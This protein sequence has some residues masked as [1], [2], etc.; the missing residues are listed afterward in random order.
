MLNESAA[1]QYVSRWDLQTS[2]G[3]LARRNRGILFQHR[4]HHDLISERRHWLTIE[5]HKNATL[6]REGVAL[7]DEI[8]DVV[9]E[10]NTLSP[11]EIFRRVEREFALAKMPRIGERVGTRFSSPAP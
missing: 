10:H 7:L 3:I 5:L 11:D 1:G 2:N 4:N 6:L 8:S 9:M